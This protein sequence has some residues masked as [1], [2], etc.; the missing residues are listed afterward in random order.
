MDLVGQDKFQ[1]PLVEPPVPVSAVFEGSE[2]I[3]SARGM[4]RDFLESLQ[5]VHGLPV[6]MRAMGMV[7]LLVSELVTNARKYAPGPCLLT[8]FIEQ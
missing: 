7:Q 3:A 8:G 5:A 1:P 2:D 6:S 4:A